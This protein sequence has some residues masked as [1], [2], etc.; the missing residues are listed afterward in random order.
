MKLDGSEMIDD[1]EDVGEEADACRETSIAEL[2][3]LAE[4]FGKFR[5]GDLVTVKMFQQKQLEIVGVLKEC[6]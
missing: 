2:K 6:R 4:F 1:P 3:K 5:S